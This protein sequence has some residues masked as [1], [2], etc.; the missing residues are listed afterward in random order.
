M[1]SKGNFQN[2]YKCNKNWKKKYFHVQNFHLKMIFF[3]QG[4]DDSDLERIVKNGKKLRLLDVR[5]CGKISD[6]G[7]VRVPAWDLE[8]LYLS[9][10]LDSL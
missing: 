4:M 1:W 9:G 8:H 7:M 6:S 10:N 2:K 3:L 5:G